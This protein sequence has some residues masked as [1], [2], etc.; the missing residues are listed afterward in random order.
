MLKISGEYLTD[1]YVTYW[2]DGERYKGEVL[3]DNEE[4]FMK[5]WNN[6]RSKRMMV[7]FSGKKLNQPPTRIEEISIGFAK[8]KGHRR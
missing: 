1:I 3:Y 8:A 2:I 7:E 4:E 5:L 6:G